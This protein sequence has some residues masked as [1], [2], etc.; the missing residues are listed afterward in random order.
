MDVTVFS[1]C[2][3]R[4]QGQAQALTLSLATFHV[5]K[6]ILIKEEAQCAIFEL[7]AKN[8]RAFGK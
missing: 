3:K 1:F 6:T 2:D 4:K 5:M 7:S 8:G